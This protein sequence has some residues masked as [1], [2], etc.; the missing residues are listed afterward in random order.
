ML[1]ASR[2]RK[3]IAPDTAL[4]EE[5]C[6]TAAF[7]TAQR[8]VQGTALSVLKQA[9]RPTRA[10]F[11]DARLYIR[12]TPGPWRDARSF[13]VD[14]RPACGGKPPRVLVQLPTNALEQ[15]S[16]P[17]PRKQTRKVQLVRSLVGAV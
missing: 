7:A 13:T 4:T 16:L 11:H 12:G 6:N 14:F 9:A 2:M 3:R 15:E 1:A 8:L 17:W 5:A 10:Q